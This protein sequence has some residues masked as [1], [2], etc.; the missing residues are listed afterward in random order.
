MKHSAKFQE[1]ERTVW[2]LIEAGG[3]PA[4]RVAD[5]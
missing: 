5:V 4:A 3:G 2:G 1:L